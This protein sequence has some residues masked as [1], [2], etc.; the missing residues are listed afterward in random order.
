MVAGRTPPGNRTQD[1]SPCRKP[2]RGQALG[3]EVSP[4]PHFS[5]L[6]LIVFIEVFSFFFLKYIGV[7]SYMINV[8]CNLAELQNNGRMTSC[9][10]AH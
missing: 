2:L 1:Y 3:C 6:L 7:T 5:L 9:H 4:L 10:D 8:I